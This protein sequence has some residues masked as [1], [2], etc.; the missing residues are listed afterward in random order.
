MTLALPHLPFRPRAL[1]EQR[2]L[3]FIF[4]QWWW[5][6]LPGSGE[7][8]MQRLRG[9]APGHSSGEEPSVSPAGGAGSVSSS[10]RLPLLPRRA[11]LPTSSLCS[12]ARNCLG[13]SQP[14]LQCHISV[15]VLLLSIP[16]HLDKS[17]LLLIWRPS[18]LSARLPQSC[19]KPF[20]RSS[21]N[22]LR[23]QER[24]EAHTARL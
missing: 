1:P 16:L 7:M 4:D 19:K 9:Q 12:Q 23:A 17:K 5:I 15:Q 3:G 8:A 10:S 6:D 22:S 14:L 21:P 18:P 20:S 13:R 2:P 24:S 11:L